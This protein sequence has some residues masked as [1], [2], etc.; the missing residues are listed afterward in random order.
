MFYLSPLSSSS[1]LP[2]L[3]RQTSETL[4]VEASAFRAEVGRVK[5]GIS[6]CGAARQA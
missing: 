6:L 1:L 2:L 4:L 3:R 5:N